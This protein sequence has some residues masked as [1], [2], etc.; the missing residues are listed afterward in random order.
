MKIDLC[1]GKQLLG[2][3]QTRDVVKVSVRLQ[4]KS[5]QTNF[6]GAMTLKSPQL[7]CLEARTKVGGCWK[8]L[9]EM[10]ESVTTIF[11][12]ISKS[13]WVFITAVDHRGDLGVSACDNELVHLK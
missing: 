12:K 3:R 4:D 1:V 8:Y 11:E 6:R 7:S 9:K 10:G 13:G 2:G 5:E